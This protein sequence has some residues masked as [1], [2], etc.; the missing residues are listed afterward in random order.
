[1]PCQSFLKCALAMTLLC[2]GILAVPYVRQRAAKKGTRGG[3]AEAHERNK[4]SSRVETLLAALL[5]FRSKKSHN[6]QS[7]IYDT[8]VFSD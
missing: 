1:V 4:N 5:F 2:F 3:R 8:S 7:D 6:Y